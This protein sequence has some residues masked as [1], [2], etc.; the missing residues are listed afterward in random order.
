MANDNN[1]KYDILKN[2][3]GVNPTT[4]TSKY[5]AEDFEDARF[6]PSEK[7]M[8][9]NNRWIGRYHSI[10]DA[11]DGTYE[12]DFS[13]GKFKGVGSSKKG[14]SIYELPDGYFSGN[15]RINSMSFKTKEA[16]SDYL[17]R[18]NPEEHK[19]GAYYDADTGVERTYRG[20]DADGKEYDMEGPDA[21]KAARSKLNPLDD[22]G[23]RLFIDNKKGSLH[24]DYDPKTKKLIAGTITNV[25]IMPMFEI[26]YD[27]DLPLQTNLENLYNHVIEEDPSWLDDDDDGE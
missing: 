22:V 1:S 27:H 26:D 14:S 16:A 15:P 9:E 4:K 13:G 25:G 7:T 20:K 17:D 12:D 5:K 11:F 10:H 19:Y 21:Y 8:D 6:Y 18:V 2:E 23:S 24:L 3:Y